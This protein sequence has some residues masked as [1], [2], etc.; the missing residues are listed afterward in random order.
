MLGSQKLIEGHTFQKLLVGLELAD[1]YLLDCLPEAHSVDDPEAASLLCGSGGGTV[2]LVEESQLSETLAVFEDLGGL[3]VDF[4]LDRAGLDDVEAGASSTL[5]EDNCAL[6]H[7]CP[8]H[9]LHD[10]F[11]FPFGEIVEDEVV[12]EGVQYKFLVSFSLG[13]PQRLDA[14]V[15]NPHSDLVET[16]DLVL[17]LEFLDHA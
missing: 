5:P 13:L 2:D 7:F 11:E 6:G 4:D 15:P 14:L 16:V 12:F 8:K 1:N 17:L 9:V 10:I 3:L